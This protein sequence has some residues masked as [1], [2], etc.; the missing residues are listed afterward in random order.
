MRIATWNIER[1]F[2]RVSLHDQW[3]WATEQLDADLIVF[4]E[5][6]VPETGPPDGWSAMWDPAGV[7]PDGR[8]KWGTVTAA[9]GVEVRPVGTMRRMFRQVPIAVDWPAAVQV[10]EVWQGR[11]HWATELVDVRGGEEHFP[12]AW[13]LSDHAPVV[14]EFR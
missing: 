9:R 11:K 14:A 7:Y 8:R 10:A 1:A 13:D 5:A 12:A 2:G 4:T 6:Q 3:K